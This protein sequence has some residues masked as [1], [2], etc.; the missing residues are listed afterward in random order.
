MSRIGALSLGIETP[1]SEQ[2]II[3]AFDNG[4]NV[5]GPDVRLDKPTLERVHLE[6]YRSDYA[7][8]HGHFP[9][10]GVGIGADPPDFEIQTP[11]G[12][13]RLDCMVLPFEDRR[14]AHA[15]FSRLRDKL[16]AEQR[17]FSK[18]ADC[19]VQIWFNVGRGLPP[20]QGDQETVDQ[21]I[22]LL[23]GAEID[24]AAIAAATAEIMMS[25]FPQHLP[26]ATMPRQTADGSAGV[27]IAPQAEGWASA[28]GTPFATALGFECGLAM[29]TT[30]VVSDFDAELQ[31]V[32][33]QHDQ[34]EI[35]QAL[36]TIGGPD[37]AGIR[38]PGEDVLVDFLS[39][40]RP[41]AIGPFEH[42]E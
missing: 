5:F 37:K 6:R 12:W 25:G 21:L 32:L 42:L 26:E 17:D 38:Y 35:Q 19:W 14:M 23:E 33:V 30:W 39:T 7:M 40:P 15:L 1:D 10:E 13:K 18:I 20:K 27:H 41:L 28:T 11:D 36:V 16:V 4:Q 8:R 34:P 24:R 3:L 29:S 9:F 22:T 31:R 2:G